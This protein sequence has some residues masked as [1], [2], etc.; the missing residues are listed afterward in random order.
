MYMCACREDGQPLSKNE[1][2]KRAKDAEKAAKAA[3]R[4]KREAEEAAAKKAKDEQVCN[5]S[6]VVWSGT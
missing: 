6:T 1:I 3:A 4:A 5:I 2:K